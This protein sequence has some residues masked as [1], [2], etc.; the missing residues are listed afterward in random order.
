MTCI[1]R[2]HVQPFITA[3]GSEIRELMAYRNA[4][5][6]RQS[7]AEARLAP[8]QATTRHYHPRTEEIYYLLQGT[9]SMELNGHHRPVGPGDTI[10]IPPGAKHQLTNT[11]AQPLVLLCCCVPA[12]EHFDTILCD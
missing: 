1:Q 4:P 5:I 2:D 8:G 9:G 11:G 10:A 6:Q 3:D 12:Y 7:L